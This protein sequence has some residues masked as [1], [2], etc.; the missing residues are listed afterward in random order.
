MRVSTF[1]GAFALAAAVNGYPLV[2]ADVAGSHLVARQPQLENLSNLVTG[3]AGGL[4]GFLNA[5][6]QIKSAFGGVTQPAVPQAPAS[7]Q[8]PATPQLPTT[9]QLPPQTFPIVNT[10]TTGTVGTSP[11]GIQGPP[12]TV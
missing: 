10:P 7:P 11:I 8:A 4:T 12:G 2:P 5:F 9:P 1:L 3:I 6:N